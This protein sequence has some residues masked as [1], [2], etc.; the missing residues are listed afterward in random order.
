[1]SA[2]G[3]RVQLFLGEHE[4]EQA[5]RTLPHGEVCVRSIRSPD[6]QTENEDSAAIIQ[7]GDDSLVLAVA[8]GVGGSAAGREASNATVRASTATALT[9]AA[10]YFA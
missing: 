1:M 4:R 10:P 9:L 7:L 3:E 2:A 8:D 5:D 6:K